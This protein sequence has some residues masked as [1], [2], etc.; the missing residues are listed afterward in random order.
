ML[1]KRVITAILIVIYIVSIIYIGGWFYNLSVLAFAFIGMHEIYNAFCNKGYRPI[2][3]VGYIGISVF[4]YFLMIEQNLGGMLTIILTTIVGLTVP[5]FDSERTPN[6]IAL[7]ILGLI[8]PGMISLCLIPLLNSSMYGGYLV[9]LI[10]LSTWA[11]DTFAFFVGTK[12]GK[13]PL[14]PKISPK[15]TIEGSIGGL[16]GSTLVG[17]LM[18]L[19]Y[20]K[21]LDIDL[22][23]YHYLVMGLLTGVFGQLGDL[24]ASS[25]KRY[26]GIKDFG[27]ILPGHGGI[28]DRFDSILFAMPVIFAYYFLFFL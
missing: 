8:Y 1:K 28:M 24:I 10:Y 14:I 25:I 5:M 22:S 23:S 3:A 7:T 21:Y 27:R 17:I 2:K 4:F 26:C 12:F 6:D 9:V 13:S 11:S 19:L 16:I 18:G 15:K 20:N